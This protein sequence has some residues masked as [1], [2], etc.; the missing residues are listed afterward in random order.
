M[1]KLNNQNNLPKVFWMFFSKF[2]VLIIESYYVRSVMS[3][4]NWYHPHYFI[5]LDRRCNILGNAYRNNVTCFN[6][7]LYIQ[8]LISDFSNHYI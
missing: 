7:F 8:E 2:Y 5:N 6:D 4:A 3:I 1:R